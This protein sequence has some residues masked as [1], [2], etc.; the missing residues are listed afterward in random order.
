MDFM[1]FFRPKWKH[2][3]AF[4]RKA[5]VESLTDQGLLADMAK[6]DSSNLVR[7]AAVDKLTDQL[8]LAGIVKTDR[9]TDVRQAAIKKVTDERVLADIAKTDSIVDLRRAAVEKLTDQGLLA[10]IA[11][12]ESIDQVR[13]AA[14]K[15]LTDER[16]LADIAT[17][18][19]GDICEL[20]HAHDYQDHTCSRCGDHEIVPLSHSRDLASFLDLIAVRGT[21]PLRSHPLSTYEACFHDLNYFNCNTGWDAAYEG[22]T[23][24]IAELTFA[25]FED[26]GSL[27]ELEMTVQ[28]YL[29]LLSTNDKAGEYI[30]VDFVKVYA[31]QPWQRLPGRSNSYAP[32]M[33]YQV[34]LAR[35]GSSK[36]LLI[37][38]KKAVDSRICRFPDIK[39]LDWNL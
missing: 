24:Q 13:Q 1:D 23:E 31:A 7:R 3:D 33:T 17:T 19:P 29:H 28:Q 37:H 38:T 4:V 35:I 20:L 18:R 22:E 14:I 32:R 12:T 15:K 27:N 6:T 16:V 10:D 5:A 26:L 34:A 25:T 39:R 11:K 2:S 21:R 9:S 36:A 8:V 30:Y